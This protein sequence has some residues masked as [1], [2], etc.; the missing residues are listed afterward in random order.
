M[1]YD[2]NSTTVT[3]TLGRF[4][5]GSLLPFHNDTRHRM[6]L[7][8]VG[9]STERFTLAPGAAATPQTYSVTCGEH[10]TISV[11]PGV[12]RANGKYNYGH[13]SYVITP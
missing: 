2:C 1:N 6:V 13:R 9:A 8:V 7:V 4:V 12:Q 5:N 10:R 11:T 3:A